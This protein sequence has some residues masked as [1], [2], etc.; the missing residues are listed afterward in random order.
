MGTVAELAELAAEEGADYVQVLA[1]GRPWGGEP[2]PGELVDYFAAVES[3]SPLPIVAYHNP[4][5]GADPSLETWARVT[6]LAGVVALKESSRDLSKIGRMIEAVDAPGNCAY[7]TTMQPLLTTLLLGGSGG[8]MPPPG[9]RIG[10]EVVS[11]V[12]AGD[13]DRARSWQRLF[14]LFPSTWGGYGLPPVMKSA[15]RHF[16]VDLGD[17]L[18]PFHPVS[19]R[20]HA[21]IGRFLSAAGVLDD[22][23]VPDTKVFSHE[24]TAD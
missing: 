13:L 10:A 18:P 16:G 17:P 14:N 3:H 7:L 20:H 1:P 6:E 23:E 22:P 11:A 4:R 15:M 12:R 9:T 2:S 5:C 8:T 21:E 24:P 19:E